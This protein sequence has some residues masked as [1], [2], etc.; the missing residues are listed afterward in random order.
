MVVQVH[1]PGTWETKQ[2]DHYKFQVSLGNV[3]SS[4]PTKTLVKDTVFKKQKSKKI[5]KKK[6]KEKLLNWS[7]GDWESAAAAVINQLNWI[8]KSRFNLSKASLVAPGEDER[9]T[10]GTHEVGAFNAL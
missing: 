5:R 6:D 9:T 4:G 7:S 10:R 1:D 2:D 3:V 8:N